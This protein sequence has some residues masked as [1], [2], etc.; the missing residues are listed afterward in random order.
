MSEAT[1]ELLAQVRAFDSDIKILEVVRNRAGKVVYF[2]FCDG[3][4][5][6]RVMVENN[7]G[8]YAYY[9]LELCTNQDCDESKEDF[10]IDVV[11][12]IGL[13]LQKKFRLGAE[14]PYGM[15]L[16]GDARQCKFY[17][18]GVWAPEHHIRNGTLLECGQ[19]TFG[20]AIGRFREYIAFDKNGQVVR[21]GYQIARR[22]RK[23][24]RN[25]QAVIEDLAQMGLVPKPDW[26]PSAEPVEN[27]FTPPPDIVTR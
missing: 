11:R 14:I 24:R 19:Y 17:T 13:E 16:I 2:D 27:E 12:R 9:G 21:K 20:P 8:I 4:D 22:S 3:R 18:Q 10:P 26:W 15:G 1:D 7:H 6:G 25:Q 23:S 5:H